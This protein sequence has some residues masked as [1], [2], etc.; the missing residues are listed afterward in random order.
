MVSLLA[1]VPPDELDELTPAEELDR[2]LARGHLEIERW[3]LASGR[4]HELNPAAYTGEAIFGVLSLLL[5]DFAP[6][7][8]RYRSAAARLAAVPELLESAKSSLRAAP[9]AWT[10]RAV[11]E[12]DGALGFLDHGVARLEASAVLAAPSAEA[13]RAFASFREHLLSELEEAPEG[14]YACGEEAFDLILK[15]AHFLEESASEIATRAREELRRSEGELASGAPRFGSN[16][17]REVLARLE[18]TRRSD[19]LERCRELWEES[20]AFAVEHRLVTWPDY[21][22]DFVPQPAWAR[23]AAP[24]LYFLF[25][26]SP[27]PLDALPRVD[28]LLPPSD[29]GIADSVLKMNH[30]VHHAGLGHHVQNWHASRAAS[31]IGRVAA[32][33]CAYRIAM[34]CGGTM[35]EGWAS[36]ATDLMDEAGFLTPLESFAEHHARARAA[37]RAIVDVDLHRGAMSFDDAESFYRD[38]TNMS[39]AAARSEATKNSMFPG[40]ALI[41]FVGSHLIREIRREHEGRLGLRG[42]H[43]RFLSYGSIPVA[44]IGRAMRRELERKA[45]AT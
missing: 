26:R 5:R 6:R 24:K 35:A 12:C 27:A 19:T 18:E 15:K 20:R 30:V 14:A 38:H 21:P 31:K 33:D 3:E 16:D 10:E 40:A 13:R 23:E 9:R 29:S 17:Y 22:V 43:D 7:D 39:E 28:H 36:Y 45:N 42:F 11:R 1:D 34:P 37:S 8:G 2:E 44:S 25:Y 4:I 32:V 41:Y